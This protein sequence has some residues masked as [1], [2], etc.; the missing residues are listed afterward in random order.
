M[1]WLLAVA[2]IVLSIPVVRIATSAPMWRA[3]PKVAGAA[4]A[5]LTLWLG[6]VCTLAAFGVRAA[7]IG[8]VGAAVAAGMCWAVIRTTAW[9]TDAPGRIR[10]VPTT[11]LREAGHFRSLADRWGPVFAHGSGLPHPTARPSMCVVDIDIGRDTLRARHDD[12]CPWPRAPFDRAVPGGILRHMAD[13]DHAVQA[14]RF[15]AAMTDAVVERAAATVDGL[16]RAALDELSG[17]EPADHADWR[18]R[19]D[20]IASAATA[21]AIF[22]VDP[23]DP[24]RTRFFDLHR[25]LA[26]H[27]TNRSRHAGPALEELRLLAR[28]REARRVPGD[29]ASVAS[30]IAAREGD[31]ALDLAVIG[32]LAYMQFSG[33][34]DLSSLLVWIVRL[35]SSRPDVL[36]ATGDDDREAEA[37]VAET[38]RLAQ[39]EYVLRKAIRPF[40]VSGHRVP[41]GWM[42]RICVRE[43]HLDPDH[44]PDPER[45]D[46]SR[47]AT[48]PDPRGY[49]PFG[50]DNHRCLGHRLTIAV[51]ARFVAALARGY[52]LVAHSAGTDRHGRFHWQ[53]GPDFT[54][55]VRPRTAPAAERSP[56]PRRRP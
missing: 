7:L 43:A 37:V 12:L 55:E 16:T 15:R 31:D 40:D 32:N 19:T 51:A 53:P 41:A 54:A 25:A 23:G 24:D 35:T 39:S 46:P 18:V 48:S 21:C 26:I 33:T 38:L 9:R 27:G 52:E 13:A 45:F 36:A 22:G 4:A 5:A 44:W 10:L 28:E 29:G 11:P 17:G 49:A 30:E 34:Y 8:A 56:S 47:F 3:A 42:L 20:R 2:L 6:L 14:P 1:D 50:L